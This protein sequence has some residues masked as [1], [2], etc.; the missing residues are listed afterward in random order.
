MA[1]TT[2]QPVNLNALALAGGSW[3]QGALAGTSTP[4]V[5]ASTVSATNSNA[6]GVAVTITGGTLT[7]VV[8][9]G[10]QVGTTAGTY[11][12]P[13]GQTISVTYSVAPTW[14]WV[15]SGLDAAGTGG[16][17]FAASWGT[18]LSSG[19]GVQFQNNGLTWLWYYN[20]STACTASSLIGQKVQGDVFPYTQDQ[21]TLV[22][23]GSGWL[24]PW[25]PQ[26]YNQTDSSQ[27]SGAPG[28]VIGTSGVGLTCVDFS[29][30]TSLSV[31]LMQLIPA[32]P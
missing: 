12:V 21:A 7:S 3:P 17:A 13:A 4:S 25:S 10:T 24:G 27:F 30:T 9:N 23:S 6:W 16:T 8:V 32:I 5:P 15:P 22:T 2:L 26:K 19:G 18:P 14:A 28:G 31:R 1:R 29:N 20:G 11:P